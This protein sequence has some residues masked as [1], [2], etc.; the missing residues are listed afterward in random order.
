MG[1]IIMDKKLFLIGLALSLFVHFFIILSLSLSHLGKSISRKPL[2]SIEVTYQD[3]KSQKKIGKKAAFNDLKIIKESKPYQDQKVKVLAKKGNMFSAIGSR[4]K[5]ISKLKGM[6]RSSQKKTPKIA[7]LDIAEKITLSPL[8][9]E[10]I[11]NPKYLTYNDDMRET[12]SRNIKQKAYAYVNHPDFETGEVYL[13]FALAS[14]GMLKQVKIIESKTSANDYLRKVALRSIRE[15][16][17]FPPFPEGFDYPE[18][19]FNLMISFQ[20]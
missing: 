18:F 16:N 2:K 13:T 19:T 1:F 3:V 8:R 11:T 20:N 17:P 6:L 5:D 14:S 4:I 10:K 12:I 7:T 9:A 15:S